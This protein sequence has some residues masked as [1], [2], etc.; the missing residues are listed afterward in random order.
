[1]SRSST[2][3]GYYFENEIRSELVA[4]QLELGKD[5]VYFEKLMDTHIFKTLIRFARAQGF[6]NIAKFTM[7]RQPADF[8]VVIDGT[9]IFIECKSSKVST[10]F[11]IKSAFIESDSGAHQLAS[12]H[13]LLKAGALYYFII[14]RRVPYGME[15]YILHPKKL[16]KLVNR[17]K[18]TRRKA[19]MKWE[20]LEKEAIVMIPKGKMMRPWDGMLQALDL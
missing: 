12:S 11:N 16:Q 15:I 3:H 5:H 9:I 13:K 18:R 17:V 4:I 2:R 10:S 7:P 1:M 6:K 19:S 20:E 14:C 8:F